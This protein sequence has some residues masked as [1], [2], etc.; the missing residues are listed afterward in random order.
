M[1]ARFCR[2]YCSIQ[3]CKHGF[4][5]LRLSG[6]SGCKIVARKARILQAAVLRPD[7]P[8]SRKGSWTLACGNCLMDQANRPHAGCL[9]GYDISGRCL[10]QAAGQGLYDALSKW[11]SVTAWNLIPSVMI[12]SLPRCVHLYRCIGNRSSLGAAARPDTVGVLAFT[13]EELHT[14]TAWSCA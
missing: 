6:Q 5:S 13:L 2:D 1:P 12:W 9:G 14:G 11:R 4:R 3:Y 7:V 8:A 10:A